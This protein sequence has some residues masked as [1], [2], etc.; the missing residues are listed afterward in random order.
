M[1]NGSTIQLLPNVQR[2]WNDPLVH[3]AHGKRPHNV[4]WAVMYYMREGEALM[5]A[6]EIERVKLVHAREHVQID[7][8]NKW[9]NKDGKT[10]ILHIL[11]TVKN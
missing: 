2:S 1:K 9:K 5:Q 6:G 10:G 7:K 8:K 3:P 4:G 11:V